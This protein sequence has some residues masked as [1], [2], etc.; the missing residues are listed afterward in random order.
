MKSNLNAGWKY[1]TKITPFNER[2]DPLST[3]FEEFLSN[4]L[5]EITDLDIQDILENNTLKKII[6]DTNG[7]KNNIIVN[8]HIFYKDI[9]IK[10]KKFKQKL[11]DHY[12]SHGIFVKGPREHQYDRGT[13]IIE[14]S[15]IN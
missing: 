7:S 2:L 13:W 5:K 11:I 3:A 12:N 14:L 10:N 15:K 4:C 8:S 9:F 1:F 6:I